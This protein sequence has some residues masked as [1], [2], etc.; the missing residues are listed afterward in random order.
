MR[1]ILISMVIGSLAV[2]SIGLPGTAAA[3]PEPD[4]ATAAATAMEMPDV[5]GMDLQQ[6]RNVFNA[7][8]VGTGKMLDVSDIRPTVGPKLSLPNWVVCWQ[9]P[10]AGEDF[11]SSEWIGVGVSRMGESCW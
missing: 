2:G 8:A 7:V 1:K 6:A 10:S 3:E 9:A 5:T 11:M 4:P